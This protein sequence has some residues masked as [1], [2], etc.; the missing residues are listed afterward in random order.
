[1]TPDK[2]NRETSQEAEAGTIFAFG[3]QGLS[4]AFVEAHRKERESTERRIRRL[5]KALG[6]PADGFTQADIDALAA[7]NKRLRALEAS[8]LQMAYHLRNGFWWPSTETGAALDI[9]SAITGL[10]VDMEEIAAERDKLKAELERARADAERYRS[11][12]GTGAWDYH[13]SWIGQKKDFVD[14]EIDA[15]R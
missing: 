4:D 6:L 15:S 5:E 10:H 1:M 12:F 2:E 3:L 7:E 11:Q 9:H 8:V 13:E 14:A